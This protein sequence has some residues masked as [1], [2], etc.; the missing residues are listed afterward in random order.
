MFTI[1]PDYDE[2]GTNVR[3]IQNLEGRVDS[4]H[5]W[6]ARGFTLTAPALRS[7]LFVGPSVTSTHLGPQARVST[8][9][10]KV[11]AL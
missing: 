9:Q 7:L 5:G 3:I 11:A 8:G 2:P 6:T 1:R 10:I 4:P